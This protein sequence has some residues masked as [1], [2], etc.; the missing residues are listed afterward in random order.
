[1]KKHLCTSLFVVGASVFSLLNAQNIY[2]V[3]GEV[4]FGFGFSGDGGPA[5]AAGLYSPCLATIDPSGNMYIADAS[6]NVIRVVNHSTGDINTIAGNHAFGGGYSGNGGPATSAE[7]NG[8]QG[9]VLDASGNIYIADTYNNVIRKVNT[10]G[11]ISTFAGNHVIGYSGDGGAAI[12]AELNNP[13]DVAF[14]VAG[15]VYIADH[16]NNVIREVNSVSGDISTVVGNSKSGYF[17]DGGPA[18]AAE[19]NLP[20]SVTFSHSGNM[21]ITDYN[22]NLVREV[23]NGTITTVAGNHSKGFGY[24]GD[25]GSATS[26]QLYYPSGIVVD[27]IGNVFI[28]DLAN[29]VVRKVNTSGTISTVAGNNTE[30]SGYSGD[31]APATAAELSTPL[32]LSLDNAGDLFI[33]D[34]D[35]NVIRKVST[36]AAGVEKITSASGEINIYPNP[37]SGSFVVSL[38]H[39]ELVSA[40]HPV[41]EVY[42]ILGEKVFAENLEQVQGNNFINLPASTSG[43]YLYRILDENNNLLG[44]GK[45]V[46]EK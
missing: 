34:G 43:I 45:L 44:A 15:N 30:G 27:A 20:V 42:N 3:V 38:S 9:I 35:N 41:I 11:T 12:S 25:G 2:T 10:S 39:A 37:N 18:T 13:T 24:S 32:G 7:L 21:Y 5:T 16:G 17:G 23:S 31:G 19:L 8:P 33:A 1:M 29:S 4:A 46:I 6:N 14:D 36:I 22:N 28:S 40:L 26:A